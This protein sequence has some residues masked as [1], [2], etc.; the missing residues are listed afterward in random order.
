MEQRHCTI[1]F[2][3]RRNVARNGKVHLPKLFRF[4]G[5]WCVVSLSQRDRRSKA[6]Q[7]QGQKDKFSMSHL[8]SPKG[9]NN[10]LAVKV[11]HAQQSA[12]SRR[13]EGK[14]LVVFVRVFQ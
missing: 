7:K 1:E 8:E 9:L 10:R 3:L 12:N 11:H 13:G 5:T 4:S 14:G 6:C 2:L